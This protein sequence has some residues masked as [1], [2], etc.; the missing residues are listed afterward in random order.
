MPGG[1]VEILLNALLALL[2]ILVVR[3]Q[4]RVRAYFLR[5]LLLEPVLVAGGGHKDTIK[6][7]R[8]KGAGLRLRLS[9]NRLHLPPTHGAM[10]TP[11]SLFSYL[12]I[13]ASTVSA[14]SAQLDF[15]PEQPYEL[16]GAQPRDA[17]VR[18]FDRDGDLDIAVCAQADFEISVLLNDGNGNFSHDEPFHTGVRSWGMGS[19]DLNGDGWFD[20]VVTDGENQATAVEVYLGDPN[21]PG[22]FLQAPTIHAGRFPIDALMDDFNGDGLQDLAVCNNVLYGLTIFLGNGD[23]TF[24]PPY[25]EPSLAGFSSNRIAKGDFNEDGIVDLVLGGF[26]SIRLALG[27]GD[28]TFP[29]LASPSGSGRS[30]AVADF[31]MDGHLDVAGIYI[32]TGDGFLSLGDGQGG[33][34]GSIPFDAG[35]WGLD[36]A[37]EDFNL[38]GIPDLAVAADNFH[39]VQ[40]FLGRGDGNLEPLQAFSTGPEP[41]VLAAGDWDGDGW[42]DLAAPY[43]NYGQTAYI[44]VLLNQSPVE[45]WQ[46]LGHALNGAGGQPLLRGSGVASAGGTLLLDLENGAAGVPAG[47]VVGLQSNYSPLYGGIL[48]PAPDYIFQGLNTDNAGQLTHGLNLPPNTPA[49]MEL[50]FQIWML[51]NAGVQGYA[52]SNGLM[53]TTW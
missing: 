43:R 13:L 37:A 48:V 12:L 4:N 32:Y 51:D 39:Q 29:T 19:G 18:D 53:V 28:G 11:L 44:S 9:E 24:G 27:A 7:R 47:T 8:L 35:D 5:I 42:I 23:G 45:P 16:A 14:Q 1:S 38:D 40:V 30:V 22:K 49:N 17:E 15:A 34:L 50:F 21:N 46:L 26:S 6:P 20:L 33:F 31:N 36:L 25:H 3:S 2:F 41:Q 52:A 10:R